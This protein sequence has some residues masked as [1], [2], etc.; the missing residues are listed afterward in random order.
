MNMIITKPEDGIMIPIPQYPLYTAATALYGGSVVPYYLDEEAGWQLDDTELESSY[1]EAKKKGVNPKCLV[2]INP[3]NPTGAIFSEET[4][5]KIIKFGT[6][7]G[8]IIVA[9]EVYRDNIY[10]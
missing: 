1:N 2:I 4:I 8:M 5:R 10:K 3:G 9:D 6:D 7:K